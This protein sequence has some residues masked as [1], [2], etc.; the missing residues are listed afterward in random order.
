[1]VSVRVSSIRIGSKRIAFR[2]DRTSRLITKWRVKCVR[3]KVAVNV[4]ENVF[5][6]GLTLRLCIFSGLAIYK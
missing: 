5:I 1:M 4:T 2:S 6:R 3:Q